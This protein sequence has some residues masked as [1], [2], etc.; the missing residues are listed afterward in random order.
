MVSSVGRAAPLQGVGHRFDSCTTH[1]AQNSGPVVQL[2]RMPACHAGGRGFESRPV[3]HITKK[4]PQVGAFFMSR[5][6]CR[7]PGADGARTSGFD[8][9]VGNGLAQPKA[10]R[11]VG[12]MDGAHV[13]RPV[14]HTMKEAPQ[15]WGFFYACQ[16]LPQLF[17]GCGKRSAPTVAQPSVTPSRPARFGVDRSKT[18]GTNRQDCRLAQPKAARRAS[19]MDVASEL[20]PCNSSTLVPRLTVLEQSTPNRAYEPF[21]TG[22]SEILL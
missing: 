17:V 20:R 6:N 3:R 11:R 16:K 2:V 15:R 13:S 12:A 5:R 10:A 9:S 21:R 18:R 22:L 19:H 8:Q 1:H 4:A 14:R 7:G